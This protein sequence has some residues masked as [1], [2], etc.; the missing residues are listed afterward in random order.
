MKKSYA[1]KVLDSQREVLGTE[2]FNAQSD[3]TAAARA[4][5]IINSRECSG[6]DLFKVGEGGELI[7][8]GEIYRSLAMRVSDWGLADAL[9][10]EAHKSTSAAHIHDVACSNG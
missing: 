7:R 9:Q 1:I 10:V 2:H 5:D 4:L 3:M 6:G 8:L